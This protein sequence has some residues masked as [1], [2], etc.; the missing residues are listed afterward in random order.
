ML[1]DL[2]KSGGWLGSVKVVLGFIE[3]ALGFKFLSMADQTYH[4]GLLDRE[5][6]LAIWIVVFTLL[7]F[8]LLGKIRFAHDDELKHVSVT[9]LTLAIASLSFAVYMFPG[10]FGA[11]LKALSGYLPPMHTQDFVINTQGV[12]AAPSATAQTTERSNMRISCTG[13]TICRGISIWPRPKPLPGRPINPCLWT[14][15]ESVV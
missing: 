8:Y 14:L 13:L 5:V 7:G 9:R 3:V 15:R 10:M 4:W 2:P 12:V 11:P 1:K 6:Y